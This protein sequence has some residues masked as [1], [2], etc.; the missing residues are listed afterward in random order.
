[1]NQP[2][3]L[4]DRTHTTRA[5][6]QPVGRRSWWAGKGPEGVQRGR[7]ACGADGDHES[8]PANQNSAFGPPN[9]LDTM[10]ASC[11]TGWGPHVHPG[12]RGPQGPWGHVTRA[13]A[14]QG[15]PH[16]LAA[17]S[18]SVFRAE[19]GRRV[20]TARAARGAQVEP[21]TR[22]GSCRT[23]APAWKERSQGDAV[24]CKCLGAACGSQRDSRARP[25][26]GVAS[27][28]SWPSRR[29]L[30]WLGGGT[31]GASAVSGHRAGGR[32][33]GTP[34]TVGYGSLGPSRSWPSPVGLGS[35]AKE[36]HP[37]GPVSPPRGNGPHGGLTAAPWSEPGE[38]K[39]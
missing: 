15:R 24:A 2:Q 38:G 37:G 7:K 18:S 9:Q 17:A 32:R 14:G 27:E 3:A 13:L 20:P 22:Q 12:A 5:A 23:G 28:G 34:G 16:G 31:V 19:R 26:R 25:P 36:A 21:R 8:R 33:A 35:S 6:E 11:S 39:G 4:P 29:D 10:A 30:C 1:M